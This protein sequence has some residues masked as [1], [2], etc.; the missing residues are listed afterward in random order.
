MRKNELISAGYILMKIILLN[1]CSNS[2][3]VEIIA[4]M[5]YF[6]HLVSGF[7]DEEM[8]YESIIP[9]NKSDRIFGSKCLMPKY[10]AN[11]YERKSAV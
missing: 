7:L 5:V 6:C 1:N 9:S 3:S 4:V 10:T 2:M 11:G 8:K